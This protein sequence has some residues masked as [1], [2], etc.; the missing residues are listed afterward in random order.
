MSGS[1]WTLLAATLVIAWLALPARASLTISDNGASTYQIIVAKDAFPI[2]L[3]AARDLQKYLRKS[4]GA[5]LPIVRGDA[6]GAGPAIVVGDGPASRALG[7]SLGDVKAEGFRIRTVGDHLVIAGRDTAGDGDATDGRAAPQAA[8]WNGVDQFLETELDIRWFMP[9]DDGEYVPHRDR[10]VVE[11]RDEKG[12]PAM[13][14]RSM[15]ALFRRAPQARVAEVREWLRHNRNGWS[16][17]WDGNHSWHRYLSPN[18]GEGFCECDNCRA[19]DRVQWPDGNPVLSDRIVTYANEIAKRVCRAL[20]DQRFGLYAYSYYAAPPTYAKLDPHVYIMCVGNDLNTLYRSQEYADYH[21]REVLLPWR[22]MV[23]HLLYYSWAEGYG[24]DDMPCMQEQAQKRLFRNLAAA[25]VEGFEMYDSDS[26]AASGLNHYLALKMCW[27][28]NADIDALY[29]DALEKCYGEKAAPYVRQY[30]DA[31][32]RRWTRFSDKAI[33]WTQRVTDT[34]KMYPLS[35][36]IVNAGLYEECAP[37]LAKAMT[38][39]SDE[40]QQARLRLLMD[41]LEYTRMTVEL[42]QLSKRVLGE[43]PSRQEVIRARDLAQKRV[44]LVLTNQNTNLFN[45]E[46]LTFYPERNDWE[47]PFTP[48]MYEDILRRMDQ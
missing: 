32:E 21:L 9:G 26:F 29:T 8:T 11:S 33:S 23:T 38:L 4:T 46:Q 14:Y 35:M 28:P 19:L 48:G 31:V 45:G 18:D 15:G 13:T 44:D 30:F 1:G 42:Y 24:N 20:P 25:R 5:T 12:E 22:A 3:C 39:T 10:L 17:S 43:H 40:G 6:V 41:N 36:E 16:V 7:V 34:P 27:N 2:T 47:S 37:L